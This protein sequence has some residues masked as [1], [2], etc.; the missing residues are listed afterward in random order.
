MISV[1]QDE[2]PTRPVETDLAARLHGEIKFH[3][4]KSGQCSTW[5]LFRF[6]YILF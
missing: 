2:I 6:V 3:P 1:Y 5:Y 4:G